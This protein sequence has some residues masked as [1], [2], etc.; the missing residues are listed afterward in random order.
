M[1]GWKKRWGHRKMLIFPTSLF[2]NS[3]AGPKLLHLFAMLS[4]DSYISSLCVVASICR[5]ERGNQHISSYL[6]A[7]WREI[8]LWVKKCFKLNSKQNALVRLSP[9]K[10]ACWNGRKEYFE[11]S[12][13]GLDRGVFGW[14]D[15]LPLSGFLPKK[16]LERGDPGQTVWMRIADDGGDRGEP[17]AWQGGAGP[18]TVALHGIQ[19]EEAAGRLV[20]S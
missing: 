15:P 14:T 3:L 6:S 7:I 2:P 10:K 11:F 16:G 19:G 18:R 12:F 20:C 17:V 4:L 1:V 8:Q 5:T 9:F 13:P